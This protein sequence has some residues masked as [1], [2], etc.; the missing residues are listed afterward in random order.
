MAFWS[1]GFLI[2]CVGIILE[3]RSGESFQNIV[4]SKEETGALVLTGVLLFIFLLINRSLAIFDDYHNLPLVSAIAGGTSPSTYYLNPDLKLAY[5]YGLHIFGATLVAIGGMFPWSAFDLAKALTTAFSIVLLFF[6]YRK[7]NSRS[8]FAVLGAFFTIFL[9]G[10][11]WLLLLAPTRWVDM[12]SAGLTLI[13]SGAQTGPNLL[14]NLSRTWALDGGGPIAFPFA[15]V[16]GIMQPINFMMGGSG[17]LPVMTLILLLLL[18]RQKWTYAQLLMYALLLAS[19]SLSS[20]VLFLIVT[21]G[22][23]VGIILSYLLKRNKGSDDKPY[24][25]F[26][27]AL[28][29]AIGLT[30]IQGGVITE[31]GKAL[32]KVDEASSMAIAGDA[33]FRIIW[34]PS[35]I[36]SHLGELN[37][38]NPNQFLIALLEIGP[39][40]IFAP[41]VARWSWRQHRR[42]QALVGGL[43]L[44][45]IGIVLLTMIFRYGGGRD[46]TKLMQFSFLIWIILG[47]P[48]ILIIIRF[49]STFSRYFLMIA[50]SIGIFGGILLF[51]IQLTSLHKP[52]QTYFVDSADARMSREYWDT[53]DQDAQVFDRIAE[54]SVILFGR[55]VRA[56]DG[57]EV[58]NPEWDQLRRRPDVRA[59]AAGG[60]THIYLD[61]PWWHSLTIDQRATFEDPCIQR[62]GVIEDPNFGDRWL[63]SV[64]GCR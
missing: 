46:T 14:Y 48:L 24:L 45:S 37:L 15:Y 35:I 30:F 10:T 1:A 39:V 21:L 54:R 8:Q 64:T 57:L 43:G 51:G 34:P 41:F 27:L 28:G 55:P 60:Y 42:G 52:V 17:A 29:L 16:N 53:L 12:A 32:L 36:S 62:V 31:F 33:T 40:L 49:G 5:H 6:W 47:M 56:K 19:L 7:H 50:L 4:P 11:R 20:E 13:G 26:A 63:L 38:T 61:E 59:I 18:F 2:F 22:L 3:I 9:A 58:N 44:V 25:A 23:V